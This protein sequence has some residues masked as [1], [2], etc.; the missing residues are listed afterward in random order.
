MFHLA[1]GFSEEFVIVCEVRYSPV[2]EEK[3]SRFPG[4]FAA[5]GDYITSMFQG[6][7]TTAHPGRVASPRPAWSGPETQQGRAG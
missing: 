1:D 3:L 6:A 5:T 4:S 2:E 7:Q